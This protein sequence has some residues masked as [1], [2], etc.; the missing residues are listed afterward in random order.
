MSDKKYRITVLTKQLIR[1]EYN[2]EGIFEDRATQVV[3]NREFPEVEYKVTEEE[4]RL[5]IITEKLHLVYNRKLFS[6]NGLSIR[7]RDRINKM[8]STWHYGESCQDLGGTARTLD[9]VDGAIALEHGILSKDGYTWMDDSRSLILNEEGW[10]EPRRRNVI[11]VYF[12]GYGRD[13]KECLKDFYHLC[14]RQP[15]LPRYTLGNWWSRYYKYTQ[16]EY[17]ELME[18]FSGEK[19]PFTVA[20]LDMDWHVVDVDPK[21]GSGWTGYTWNRKLIPEPEKMLDKL[22]SE[23]MHVTL[24]V[25]PADGVMPY[26]EAYEPMRKALGI[27]DGD[28][29][30]PFDITDPEFLKAYFTYLHHPHEQS[31][32][33]FWW[34]DWQQGDITNVEGLDPLWMLNHYHYLDNARDEKRPLILSRYAGI[35]S[36][37]YP[38]GFSGDTII[39][40]ASLDFQPYFTANASNV[41]YGWWSHDIGGHMNGQKDDELAVRWVQYGVFSPINR[42]HSSD[43]PFDGKELWRYNK[44]AEDIMKQ[45]LRLRHRMIPYLY[46]MNRVS[47]MVGIPLLRPLYYEYPWEEA[48]YDAPNMYYFGSELLAAPITSP[49]DSRLHIA[50]VR[51]LLPPG[52]WIDIF[53]HRVYKGGRS[54]ELY[55]ELD[56]I[57]VLA[58]AGAILPMYSEDAGNHLENPTQLELQIFGGADGVF[59]LY[60]DDG[61]G[62]AEKDSTWADTAIR[63]DWKNGAIELAPVCGNIELVPKMRDYKLSLVGFQPCELTMDGRILQQSYYSNSGVTTVWVRD[64]DI[65][66]S[67]TIRFKNQPEI[68]HN[69]VEKTI[70]DF[71]NMAQMDLQLK[72]AVY[73]CV[74]SEESVTEKI[75]QLYSYQLNPMLYGFLCEILT[76]Q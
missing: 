76:A 40:W 46:T 27:K 13:Y 38:I 62:I 10:V 26:E 57:P 31:G 48:A 20:V 56:H 21:C 72:K 33:D 23:G 60:E 42:L 6:K 25:H 14:G 9:Q 16:Q 67:I 53:N 5:Q 18:R 7:L 50:K 15:L 1:L 66:K 68:S 47:S 65:N 32:V 44:I 34:I 64:A 24:N 41:G 3:L 69:P 71:L 17:L 45:F 49:M 19:I 70:F 12:W 37:R 75:S 30:I 73:D 22:H 54:M 63:L 55:R 61:C 39:S 35:G 74:R 52:V 59:H 4:H 8:G 29:G 2:E 28:T 11:D 51:V 43:N 58:K 36:H